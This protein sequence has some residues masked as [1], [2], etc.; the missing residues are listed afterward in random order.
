MFI[1]DHETEID[2]L[3]YDAIAKTVV[4]LIIRSA[5]DPLT[6]GIHGDW[7]AGKSSVLAMAQKELSAHEGVVCLRFNGWQFQGFEDAKA[8]LIETVII[9]LRD[10][11]KGQSGV[12][13]KTTAL[14]KRVD[15]LK[16]VKKG[17]PWVFSALT[18]IPHPEQVNDA[19]SLLKGLADGAK[20]DLKPDKVAA[21]VAEAE[22]ILKP[23]VEKKIPEQLCEFEKEFKELLE[24]AKIKKLVVLI[25]DLDRCLPATAI[26]T[27]EAI[28]LFLLVPK[29]A[30]VVAADEQMIEYSVRQHFP[31]LPASGPITYARNYLEKLIQVPFRLPALGYTETQAYIALVLLES[32]LGSEHESFRTLLATARENLS[33]P[34]KSSGIT[35]QTTSGKSGE[36]SASRQVSQAIDLS[37]QI[38]RI[39]T[40]GTSGNPRQIKRFLNSMLLRY[41]IAEARG[42]AADI[43]RPAL[44]KIMLAERFSPKF[45]EDLTKIAYKAPDGKSKELKAL[46]DSV[47][48]APAA[49]IPKDLIEKARDPKSPIETEWLENDFAKNWAKIDPPLQDVDL[50]PYVFVTRDKR[51]YLGGGATASPLDALVEKL[52]GS[53]FAVSSADAEV[54]KLSM[55][56]AE[57]VFERIRSRIAQNDS[58][59]TRPDGMQGLESVAKV[60]PA[61]QKRL[62]DWIETLPCSKLGGWVVVGFDSILTDPTAKAGYSTLLTN[63]A[64]QTE[65]PALKAAAANFA[66]P[67]QTKK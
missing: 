42:L 28:R 17:A 30:F 47:R 23:H 20:G 52:M 2:L 66:K 13:E 38:A 27:L 54:K 57:Q 32:E 36:G 16:L 3:Y 62:I 26:E 64:K 10:R 48:N 46:E 9:Q 29:T 59:K 6:I 12:V 53:Q 31:D 50:R 21:K 14:L 37:N 25:D 18:G 7:G 44:A 43:K 67:L 19:L 55:T 40:D 1:K 58:F 24:A 22:A 61:L 34:W 5:N 4:K 41:E 56:E 45:Y 65:N 15:Y 33:K 49:I 63:W 39:L 35:H 8:A 60:H 51:N 11:K